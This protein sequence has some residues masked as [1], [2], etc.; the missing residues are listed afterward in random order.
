MITRADKL[1]IYGLAVIAL[2]A[3]LTTLVYARTFISNGSEVVIRSDG[4][5][6]ACYSLSDER[7][8]IKIDGPL[9]KS[10][11]EI[12]SDKARMLDSPCPQKTCCAQGWITGPERAIICIPNRVV[13]KIVSAKTKT[14]LDAVSQ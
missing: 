11:V 3:L 14:S 13:I 12:S 6:V 5:E 4:R 7:R 8:T 9:G 2:V 10:V 1:I